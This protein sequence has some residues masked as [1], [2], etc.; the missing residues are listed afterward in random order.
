M[1]LRFSQVLMLASLPVVAL[2]TMGCAEVEIE[3]IVENPPDVNPY[4]DSDGDEISSAVEVNPP[5]SYLNLDTTVWDSNLCVAHG[6]P[7]NGWLEKPY[8][9]VD[10]GTGYYRYN[11]EA[12]T[13]DWGTLE[14]INIIEAAGRAWHAENMNVSLFAINDLSHGDLI[15]LTFGGYFHPHTSHQNGLDVDVRYVRSDGDTGMLN[16]AEDPKDYD[17]AA[18]STLMNRFILNGRVEKILVDMDNI[19]FTGPLLR[20]ADGHS[21]HFHIRIIDPDG[22][23]NKRGGKTLRGNTYENHTNR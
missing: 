5:N 11:T 22:T 17:T 8:N 1:K 7:T 10:Q 6:M 18:T 15:T 3:D 20:D 16:I 19:G 13:D 21:D 9:I 4:Y 12:D 23:E 2:F 14:L